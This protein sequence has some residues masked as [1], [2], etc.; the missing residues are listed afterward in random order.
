MVQGGRGPRE[1]LGKDLQL[2]F[3]HIPEPHRARRL[4]RPAALPALIFLKLNSI[5]IPILTHPPSLPILTLM[6]KIQVYSTLS[7]AV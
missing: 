2:P 6:T 3:P 5:V 4:Q 7:L 1:L